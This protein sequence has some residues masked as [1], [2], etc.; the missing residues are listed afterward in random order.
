[1]NIPSLR[2]KLL[3]ATSEQQVTDLL[4]EG[5]TYKFAA[6]ATRNRWKR[7]A[8]ARLAVLKGVKMEPEVVAKPAG[9]EVESTFV[10]DKKKNKM[11]GK[12]RVKAETVA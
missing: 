5:T 9:E 2:T 10:S 12:K 1:M 3:T 8:R 4:T 7:T 11:K 6:P